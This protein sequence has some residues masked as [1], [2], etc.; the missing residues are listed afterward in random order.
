MNA[1]GRQR[2][3]CQ[4]GARGDLRT[5]Q[6]EAPKG[7][8]GGATLHCSTR[9]HLNVLEGRYVT[10]EDA[11]HEARATRALIAKERHVEVS[12]NR[13]GSGE[14]RQDPRQNVHN[15]DRGGG[16]DSRPAVSGASD[17]D[18]KSRPEA[19]WRCSGSGK[20]A[21][22]NS[23]SGSPRRVRVTPATSTGQAK[24]RMDVY[25]ERDLGRPEHGALLA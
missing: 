11:G 17:R 7:S 9:R 5:K 1:Q 2:R 19:P 24:R 16:R 12:G 13:A 23:L 15:G 18:D 14:G 10:A 21:Q 20:S 22:N 6:G 25:P 8:R 4:G 3:G